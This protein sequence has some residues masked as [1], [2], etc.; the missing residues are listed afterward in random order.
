MDFSRIRPREQGFDPERL[1]RIGAWLQRYIDAGNIPCGQVLI[2]RQGEPVWFENRGY[3]DVEERRPLQRDS[4]F[5]IYSMTKPI[6]VVAALTLLEEGRLGLGDPVAQYLP[7][8][9][10]LTAAVAGDVPDLET[11]AVREPLTIRNLMMHTAGFTYGV[12]G[13]NTPIAEAYRAEHLDFF[14]DSPSNAEIIARLAKVPLMHQPGARWSYGISID[15][16]GVVLER[17]TGQT[18]GEIFQQR[19][20]DPL[21]MVDSSFELPAEKASRFAT[22]Y[23]RDPKTDGMVLS[24]KGSTSKYLKKVDCR[25]GGGGLQS[26]LADYWRFAEMLRCDGAYEGR[27]ILAPKTVELMTSNHLE[28]DLAAMGQKTFSETNF[29]GVGFGLGVWV[30]VNPARAGLMTSPGEFGWGGAA[31]TVFWVDPLEEVSA[32]FL[33]Q[34]VPSDSYRLRAELRNLVYQA[35]ID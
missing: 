9:S 15:V 6:T 14:P 17:I 3:L 33:T 16:L 31:S 4:I 12:F 30:M 24:D 28:G 2:S 22:L 10:D 27:R 32:L 11:E 18:L 1:A 26:T 29:E 13:G 19:V 20:F 7:E 25:S 21:G 23:A 8:L 34:L 5:R 35:M